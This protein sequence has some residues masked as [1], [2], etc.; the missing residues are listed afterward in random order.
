MKAFLAAFLLAC[1]AVILPIGPTA[2]A[3]A[4]K[5][6]KVTVLQPIPAP[7]IR[8]APWAV[9]MAQGWLAEEGLEVEMQTTKGSIIVVQQVLN[10]NAQYGLPAPEAT[11]VARAKGAP[12]R[13]FYGITSRNPFPLAV[14]KDGPVKSLKDVKGTDIG[15][16][17]LTAVQF[18]T[19]QAILQSEGFKLNKDYRLLD[20]G[21]GAGALKA[22]QDGT[23]SALSINAFTYAGFENRG[24]KLVY[25]TTP[26]MDTI[27]AWGLMATESY[28][29]AN[30]DEAVGLA[31]AFTKG[32]IFCAENPE[33]CISAYFKQFPT[34][35]TAG[36]SEQQAVA[37]HLRLLEVFLDYGPLPANGLWGS[38]DS[39]AWSAIVRYMLDSGQSAHPID[40][41]SLYTNDLVADV[42]TF[43]AAR[44]VAE[45]RAAKR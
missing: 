14:L 34:A 8:F 30:R 24:A 43:D 5:L 18:Y 41:A 15:V 36:I 20:V 7:D 3:E 25:L 17:S 23:I 32:R 21:A 33:A 2:K 26:E 38:Y 44:V 28:L 27:L 12:L 9:A 45:A 31:R 35:R 10:G 22:L 29:A 4:P 40:P 39:A 37:E 16:F 6:K 19:T 1:M 11:V 42:N 13:Y